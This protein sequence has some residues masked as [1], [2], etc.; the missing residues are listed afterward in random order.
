MKKGSMLALLGGVS[1]VVFLVATAP[2][3]LLAYALQR[4]TPVQ[5][6]GLSGSLWHGAA[7]QVVTPELKLGPLHWRLHGW[8]LLLGKVKLTLEIPPGTPHISGKGEVAVSILQQL[9]LS[10]VAVEADAGWVFTQAALPLAAAG[11]LDLQIE[12]AE[13]RR[14]ELPYLKAQ[15]DWRQA[16]IVYPQ[17]YQLG[18]YRVVLRPEPE[19]NPEYLLGEVKDIDSPLKIDGTIKIDKS[20]DYKLSARLVTA[21]NAAEIFRSTLLFLGEPAADGSVTIERNGN[22]FQDYDG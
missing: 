15:L 21:P 1:F 2:A 5:L 22:I 9:S 19:T 11:R 17:V 8:Y 12:T 10:N 3:S 4:T 7:Q 20:G 16:Q 14:E 6:Q 13:F 18:G